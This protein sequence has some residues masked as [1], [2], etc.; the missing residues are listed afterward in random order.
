MKFQSKKTF[1]YDVTMTERNSTFQRDTSFSQNSI[2]SF[3]SNN[4]NFQNFSQ[5]QFG[6]YG[7]VNNLLSN[8]ANPTND[9]GVEDGRYYSL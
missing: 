6:T 4:F 1:I 2:Q 3:H 9:Y 8:S 5:V 7:N